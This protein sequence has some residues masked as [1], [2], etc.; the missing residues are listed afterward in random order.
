MGLGRF[1]VVR[2]VADGEKRHVIALLGLFGILCH[3]VDHS[4]HYFLGS[5]AAAAGCQ[6]HGTFAPEQLVLGIERLR[7]SVCVEGERL[8]CSYCRLLQLV[9]VVAERANGHVRLRSGS[10]R[11]CPDSTTKTNGTF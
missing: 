5:H 3:L 7:Q 6:L 2:L 1:P 9:W 11:H 8:S 10:L 4:V